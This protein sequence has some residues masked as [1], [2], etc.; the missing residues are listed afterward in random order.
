MGSKS[1]EFENQLLAHIFQNAA[2]A[3]IGNAGGLPAAAAEGNLYVRLHTDAAVVDDA[4]L[5][6]ECAY[7]GYTAYG[8]AVPRNATGWAVAG[9]VAENA[10]AVAFGACTA[11][12]ETARYFSVWKTNVDAT[13]ANRIGWG[14]LTADLAITSGVTPEFA[15]G[16]LTVT[17]E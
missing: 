2:I 6:V 8:V 4:S 11:G 15:P 7:I 14:Q 9:N 3:D 12:T 13:P 10:A 5:G 1:N 17:E 16:A